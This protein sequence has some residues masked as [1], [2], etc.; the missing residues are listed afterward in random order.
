MGFLGP[1]AGLPALVGLLWVSP[2]GLGGAMPGLGEEPFPSC[3]GAILF[4]GC[5][6]ADCPGPPCSTP[7]NISFSNWWVVGSADCCTGP[8]Q[9]CMRERVRIGV[10]RSCVP[11]LGSGCGLP[12]Q[13]CRITGGTEETTYDKWIQTWTVCGPLEGWADCP[14]DC[15]ENLFSEE[16]AGNA[17]QITCHHCDGPCCSS[18]LDP[19][20]PGG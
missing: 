2:L 16:P 18:T 13:D 20:L 4:L 17:N 7:E 6:G 12:W 1:V 8:F 11:Q 9:S 14:G 19:N 3:P 15:Q 5:D 10:T